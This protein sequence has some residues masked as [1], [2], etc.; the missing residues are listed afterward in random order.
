M[1]TENVGQK[2]EV[3]GVCKDGYISGSS[4]SQNSP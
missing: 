3:E 1:H 2:E 4:E